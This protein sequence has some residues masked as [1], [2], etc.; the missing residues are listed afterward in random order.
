MHMAWTRYVTGRMKSDYQYSISIVYNNFPWPQAPASK[1]GE[2]IEAAAQ[3]VLDTRAQHPGASL[4]DLYDPRTM[5]PNLVKAHRKLDAVVD[6]SY[7][8]KK[9]LG[10]SDRVAFLFGMYQQLTSM[11]PAESKA[12]RKRPGVTKQ[13]VAA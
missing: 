10:D 12:V 1:Q 6:A 8:K 7:S 5:P 11:F 4:A 9:F 2:D 3:A 13:G